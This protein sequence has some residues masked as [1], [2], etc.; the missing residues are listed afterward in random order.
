MCVCNVHAVA[1]EFAQKDRL[2]VMSCGMAPPPATTEAAM[3]L[4]ATQTEIVLQVAVTQSRTSRLAP[5]SEWQH[6]VMTQ[7]AVARILRRHE[8]VAGDR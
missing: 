4:P 8:Q 5:G 6:L 7:R 2:I 3:W 1:H